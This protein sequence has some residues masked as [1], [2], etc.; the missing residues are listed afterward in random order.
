MKMSSTTNDRRDPV[1]APAPDLPSWTLLTNHAH[2]MVALDRD[3]DLRQRDLAYAVGLTQG[4][5]Q[6]ILDEPV[7]AG[8]RRR[9]KV[10]RRNQY[11]IVAT[12]P[13]RH[14]L[15]VKHNSGELLNMLRD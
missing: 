12:E 9:E 11:E 10:G 14:P 6:R 2:V 3:P 15:E 5:V 1:H 8:F 4:A 7:Q 13:L